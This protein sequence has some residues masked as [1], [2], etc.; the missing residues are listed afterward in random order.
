MVLNRINPLLL[1][2]LFVGFVYCGTER[3]VKQQKT[4]KPGTRW[5]FINSANSI[6]EVYAEMFFKDD[7]NLVVFSESDGQLGPFEYE[8]TSEALIF[9]N[10]RFTKKLRQ[11]G[12]TS[13]I[14]Y[15]D[16]FLLFKIPFIE[17][18]LDTNQMDPFYVRRCFFLVNLNLITTDE[19]A[20]YLWSIATV[21][22]DLFPDD[23]IIQ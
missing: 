6:N 9:N 16:E 8:E 20:K 18:G 21:S 10:F 13:L 22:E 15:N 11:E 23:E 7:S 19:A 12:Y 5:T 1:L 17:E 3:N 14:N 2:I 4:F